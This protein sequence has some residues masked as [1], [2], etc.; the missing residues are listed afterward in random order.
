MAAP[1][2][3]FYRPITDKYERRPLGAARLSEAHYFLKL[4]VAS[5][6]LP[7]CDAASPSTFA[8]LHPTFEPTSRGTGSRKDTALI[9]W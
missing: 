9:A 7:L 2:V 5:C 6:L 8:T 4:A 3:T 1:A